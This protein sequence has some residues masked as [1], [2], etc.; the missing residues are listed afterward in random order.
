MSIIASLRIY[1]LTYPNWASGAPLHVDHIGKEIEYGIFPLPVQP[2]LEAYL[3]GSS[4]RQFA[5]AIQSMESIGD[6]NARMAA[7]EFYETL[8][9]WLEVQTKRGNLPTMDAGKTAET[10]EAL[11]SGFLFEFGDSGM[12][13]YQIQCRLTYKQSA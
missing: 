3:D 12:G 10:I 11:Q 4:L 7:S 8:A 9:D 6:N 13:V 5:F 2:I 1:L